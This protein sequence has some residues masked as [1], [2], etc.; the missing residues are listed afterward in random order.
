MLFQISPILI[1]SIGLH[2]LALLIPVP[3]KAP[4]KEPEIELPEPISVTELPDISKPS[5]PIEPTFTPAPTVVPQSEPAPVVVSPPPQVII[6][7]QEP[8]T[9]VPEILAEPLSDPLPSAPQPDSQPDPQ[10][11]TPQA[12]STEEAKFD[13][14][15]YAPFLE[16]DR[17]TI[18]HILDLLYPANGLCFEKDTGIE[19]KVVV[20]LDKEAVIKDS[21]TLLQKTGYANI[22]QWL[23]AY[24]T[25]SKELPDDAFVDL[26]NQ[27]IENVPASG[28]VIDWVNAARDTRRP[29]VLATQEA[30]AYF[31]EV[32]VSVDDNQCGTP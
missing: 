29:L 8:V 27:G 32:S 30:A 22:D 24:I 10:P 26:R 11:P 19:A 20:V 13:Q 5:L 15:S 14:Q 23:K 31:I 4:P 21:S 16:Y 3:D 25:T 9:E 18:T 28:D 6:V 2:G 7:E 1:V 12:Y 17:N